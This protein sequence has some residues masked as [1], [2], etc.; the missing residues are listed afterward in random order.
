MDGTETPPATA[1]AVRERTLA[2]IPTLPGRLRQ[3][4]EYLLA[5]PERIAVSTVAELAAAAGVQPSAMMRFCQ[6]IGFSGFSE[7]QRLYRDDY[8]ER[9][10]DY[11]T[12]LDRLRARGGATAEL[13]LDF[14]GAGHRSLNLLGETT[15]VAALERATLLLAGAETVHLVGFRRSFPVASYLFYVFEKMEI[16]AVLHGASGGLQAESALRPGDVAIVATV[17]P[18]SAEAVKIARAAAARD[19]PV[20]AITDAT[21]GPL[22]GLPGVTLLVREIDVGAFRALS[23]TLTLATALAVGTGAARGGR[24]PA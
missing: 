5:H 7:M 19:L 10:P 6:V 18:Y 8:A 23:A 4:A 21:D 20:V 24:T 15:D 3:C 22:A 1:D 2:A 16:P 12:R 14:V 9:W 11:A 17:A 13:L